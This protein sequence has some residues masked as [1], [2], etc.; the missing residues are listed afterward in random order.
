M[1]RSASWLIALFVLATATAAV[2]DED[3]YE[4]NFSR[5]QDWDGR[6][7]IVDHHFG[8]VT[9]QAEGSNRVEIRATI[10]ASDPAFGKQIRVHVVEEPTTIKVR[11]EYPLSGK[12]RTATSSF[13]VDYVIKVPRRAAVQI[14]NR[15][16]AI[17][18]SGIAGAVKLTNSQGSIWVRESRGPLTATNA[19]GSITVHDATS[20]TNVLRNQNGSIDVRDINGNLDVSNRFGSVSVASVDGNV[21]LR[22]TNGSMNV[23]DILRDL[24]VENAFADMTVSDIGGV[25]RVINTN[26]RVDVRDIIRDATIT[27][28]FGSVSATTVGG[29][30]AVNGQ[31]VSVNAKEVGGNVTV[32]TSFSPVFLKEIG[33]AVDIRN[34]NGSIAVSELN[35]RVCQPLIVRTSLS[36][37]KVVLPAN[38][39]YRVNARNSNGQIRSSV[40]VRSTS[41]SNEALIG[42]IGNGKCTMELVNSNGSITIDED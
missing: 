23:K 14:E 31:N 12:M 25:L 39:S 1:A 28:S 18:V 2:A 9:V 24:T 30:L 4:M 20:A 40:P 6:S 10:R 15:F 42:I 41:S 16:G 5:T 33:G 11:T 3:R 29:A 13:S 21:I 19:F 36:A 38:A 35:G 8:S 17:N 34:N 32:R 27:N 26:G 22:N 37:V 7:L